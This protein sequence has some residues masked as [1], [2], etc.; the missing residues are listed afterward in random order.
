MLAMNKQ[1]QKDETQ[2]RK[3]HHQDEEK[4]QEVQD[5]VERKRRAD[6]VRLKQLWYF[7][8]NFRWL[9]SAAD[10]LLAAATAAFGKGFSLAPGTVFNAAWRLVVARCSDG[11]R[12]CAG[13][14]GGASGAAPYLWTSS[15]AGGSGGGVGEAG[16]RTLWWAFSTAGLTTEA[17]LRAGYASAG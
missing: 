3:Q 15:A 14:T 13:S 16:D 8:G 17:A 10:V 9:L 2:R 12:E 4:H 1:R 5:K 6:E 7:D 11:G